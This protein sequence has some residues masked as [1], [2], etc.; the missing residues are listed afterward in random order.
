MGLAVALIAGAVLLERALAHDGLAD[1]ECGL[2]SDGLGL[3]DGSADL[4]SI[5]AVDL[6]DLPAECA[7]LGCGVLVHHLGGLGAEL[8]V[9]AVIEHHDVVQTQCACDAGCS[10]RDLLLHAAV[11]DVDVDGLLGEGGVAGVR[12]QELGSDGSTDAEGVALTQRAAGVL[13]ATLGVGLGVSRCGRAPLA[14]LLQLFERELAD[15]CELA[16]EHGGH[17]AGVEEEAVAAHPCRVGGVVVEIFAVED[18]DE[19]GTAHGTA[20]V[21][22]LGLLDHRSG[23]DADIVRCMIQDFNVVHCL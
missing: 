16:V 13:D 21:T 9:I 17:V 10:L 18:V 22:A 3:L 6:E 12:G 5:V 8:D 15:Q 4:G 23:K 2:A 19:V 14:E 7:V 20:G 1:D 11:G